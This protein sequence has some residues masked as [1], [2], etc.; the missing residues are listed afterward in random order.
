MDSWIWQP[1]YPLVSATLDGASS[2]SASSASPSARRSDAATWLVPVLVRN[3]G[4]TE[5]SPPRGRRGADAAHRPGRSRRRQRRRTRVLS[6]RLLQRSCATG[7]SGGAL[8]ELDTLGALHPGRRRLGGGDRRPAERARV[9]RV[10]R[11]LRRR[12]RA[13]RLAGDPHRPA[14]ARTVPRR[15]RLP[16]LPGARRHPAPPRRRRPRRPVATARATSPA[17]CAGS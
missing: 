14:R 12:A 2:S 5:R 1:G 13:R 9:P 17:S 6:R 3:G 8:A 16:A 7:S 11:G 4:V 15:R 10:R